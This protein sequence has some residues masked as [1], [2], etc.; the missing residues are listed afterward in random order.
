MS[1]IGRGACALF[2]LVLSLSAQAQ[3]VIESGVGLTQFGKAI[4]GR[5]YQSPFP[6]TLEMRSVSSSIGIKY[7]APTEKFDNLFIRAGYEYQGKASSSA[8]A[9]ASDENY[10]N[11]TTGKETCWPM[12]HWYGTGDVSG[13]YLTLVPERMVNGTGFF[14]EAG[15]YLYRPKWEVNI[16][17]WIGSREDE[18]HLVHVAHNP[19]WQVAPML[20]FGVRRG[21]WAIAYTIKRISADGDDYPA[22]Y[23]KATHNLSIRFTF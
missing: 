10:A 15:V 1:F 14:A 16:P 8:E 17:D 6:H 3:L 2:L 21:A 9:T 5:W 11:C 23:D 19:K 7:R 20:G 13:V 4:D 22:I 18:P 12:S